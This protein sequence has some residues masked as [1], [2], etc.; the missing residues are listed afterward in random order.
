MWRVG[1]R[2]IFCWGDFSLFSPPSLSQLREKRDHALRNCERR[3]RSSDD[4]D[5]EEEEDD[6]DD[7]VELLLLPKHDDE[8]STGGLDEG[9]KLTE[10]QNCLRRSITDEDDDDVVFL[11]QRLSVERLC[12]SFRSSLR[13]ELSLCLSGDCLCQ[14][15][16]LSTLPLV[17]NNLE[18]D[19]CLEDLGELKQPP[20]H[21]TVGPHHRSSDVLS[22]LFP[23]PRIRVLGTD[24]V[25]WCALS[26]P[27]ADTSLR[28]GWS[29]L[30]TPS[31][32][33]SKL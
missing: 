3:L 13:V 27:S 28:F 19:L 26:W 9:G 33:S 10:E 30:A 16:S 8:A 15:I 6:G 22:G 32:S 24:W 11:L 4:D 2:S 1:G 7:T 18:A 23:C 21:S 29:S 20:P 17:L 12:L 14:S 31:R 5:D 25:Y